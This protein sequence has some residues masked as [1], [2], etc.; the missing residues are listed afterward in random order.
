MLGQRLSPQESDEYLI[1]PKILSV[2]DPA[3]NMIVK[4]MRTPPHDVCP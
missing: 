3:S 2:I 4:A 1:Y